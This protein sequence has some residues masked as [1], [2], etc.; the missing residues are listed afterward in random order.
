MATEELVYALA[1]VIIAAAWVDGNISVEE[2]NSL[3]DLLFQIEGM[4]ASDWAQLEIYMDSPVGEDERERLIADLHAQTRTNQDKELVMQS[5][6][7]LIHADG[8]VSDEEEAAIVEITEGINSGS[9]G[10]FRSLNSLMRNPIDRQSE[11]IEGSPNREQYLD[12]FINNKVY[13]EVRRRLDLGDTELEL[14]D[15]EIKKL[16]LAGGMLARIAEVDENISEEEFNQ[17]VGTLENYWGIQP[18]AAAFVAEVAITEVG[19]GMD[20]FR[21]TR[22]IVEVSTVPERE[23]FVTTLFRIAAADGDVSFSETEEIRTISNGLK[24]SHKQ[25]IE[26][27]LQGSAVDA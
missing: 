4:T 19:K 9:T 7:N 10:V 22:E 1:K 2:K 6:D 11:R 12:D 8:V 26:A 27:K 5:L 24:L 14:P 13:Y 20:F 21:M 17:I 3:K 16:S 23:Q 25:F 18:E 15:D